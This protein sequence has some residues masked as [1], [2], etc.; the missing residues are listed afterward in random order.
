MIATD[1]SE[2]DV[3]G[4]GVGVGQKAGFGA[5][6]AV[7]E[8]AAVTRAFSENA[9]LGSSAGDLKILANSDADIQSITIG[10][11]GGN[12]FALGG[13]VSLGDV[14]NTTQAYVLGGNVSSPN[15]LQISALDESKL[16]IIGGGVA[17]SG[18]AA[19]G[20][21]NATVLTNNV[22][23]AFVGLNT[24]VSA[25]G[26]GAGLSVLTGTKDASGNKNSETRRGVIVTAVS[27]EDI[28]LVAAGGAG[29]GTAGIAGLASV[30]V[31]NET[32]RAFLDVGATVNPAN[33]AANV[34]QDV[35]VR[36]ADQTNIVGVGGALAGGG[37]VGI[38]VGVDVGTINK[39][40][41]AFVDE[42]TDVKANRDIRVEALSREDIVSVSASAQG[43]ERSA[44]WDPQAFT[45]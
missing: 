42:R 29:G 10:G 31:L 40:T 11:A 34:A 45:F 32:T 13:S 16:L 37:N 17:G 28:V 24:N 38:G 27:F 43:A 44:W 9:T 15:S 18:Q 20:L 21:G 14:S 26:A 35:V 39:R 22:V 6:V 33:G 4:G 36:A 3:Y 2:I 25:M 12:N 41:E 5:S 23:E 19:V 8:V 30:S 1:R 7:N